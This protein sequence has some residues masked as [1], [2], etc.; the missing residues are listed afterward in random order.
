MFPEVLRKV[1][2][3]EERAAKELYK[4]E[5]KKEQLP[6]KLVQAGRTKFGLFS[7]LSVTYN[8]EYIVNAKDKDTGLLTLPNGS[9]VVNEDFKGVPVYINNL[10]VEREAVGMWTINQLYKVIVQRQVNPQSQYLTTT[11]LFIY[12]VED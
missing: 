4:A 5:L 2:A 7:N 10:P 12:A 6:E 8:K 3:D 9:L 1:A 11:G